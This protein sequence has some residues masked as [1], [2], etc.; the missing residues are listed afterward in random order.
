LQIEILYLCQQKNKLS[1]DKG[2]KKINF[3]NIEQIEKLLSTPDTKKIN[4]LRDKAILE[5]LF[6][7]GLRIA[8]LVSLNRDQIRI[9]PLTEDLEN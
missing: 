1:K 5:T 4:G 8:E 2:E 7:T 6:S 9:S 3:L